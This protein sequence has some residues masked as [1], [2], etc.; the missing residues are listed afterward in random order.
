MQ[1]L[2]KKLTR[3]SNCSSGPFKRV[4]GR[5]VETGIGKDGQGSHSGEDHEDPEEHPVHYHGNILPVLLQLQADIKRE[6]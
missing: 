5:V 1:C 3:K 4:G 6:N 2:L